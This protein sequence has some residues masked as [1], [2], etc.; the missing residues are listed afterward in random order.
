MLFK[1]KYSLLIFNLNN[2]L[3]FINK[4]KNNSLNKFYFMFK[5]NKLKILEI[6]EKNIII[7]SIIIAKLEFLRISTYRYKNQIKLLFYL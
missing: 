4:I 7:V 5:I 2:S 1:K 3:Y 6:L